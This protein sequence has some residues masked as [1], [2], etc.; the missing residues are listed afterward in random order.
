M[1][2]MIRAKA[3]NVAAIGEVLNMGRNRAQEG[4]ER[5]IS[6]A[7][8]L[9]GICDIGHLDGERFRLNKGGFAHPTCFFPHEW[10][11]I[12]QS[13]YAQRKNAQRDGMA[14]ESCSH[15]LRI[16]DRVQESNKP[17]GSCRLEHD[18]LEISILPA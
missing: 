15:I 4:W 14:T 17:W 16:K 18:S 13:G 7:Q 12:G 1:R 3:H 5:A 8:K 11:F 9:G 6:F 2:H 10:L